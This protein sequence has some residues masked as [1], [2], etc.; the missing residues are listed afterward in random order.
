V[1]DNSVIF[2]TWR[3]VRFAR[4]IDHIRQYACRIVYWMLWTAHGMVFVCLVVACMQCLP[5][6][7]QTQ[8]ET[9]CCSGNLDSGACINVS[10]PR[11]VSGRVL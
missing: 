10:E 8:N 1:K 9:Q 2:I 7:S 11:V 6:G 5:N 4:R 3:R